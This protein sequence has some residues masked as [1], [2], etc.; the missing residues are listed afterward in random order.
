MVT[1]FLELLP[2]DVVAAVVVAAAFVLA[3][4][5]IVAWIVSILKQAGVVT[6]GSA[7]RWNAVISYVLLA[8]SYVL[9]QLG[10]GDLVGKVES[11]PAL[12]VLLVIAGFVTALTGKGIYSLGRLAG[13]FYSYSNPKTLPAK[14]TAVGLPGKPAAEG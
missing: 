10:Y 1:D 13:F 14:P 6:D 7:G 5:V 9:T 8:A 3:V 2:E 12:V 11:A 4:S